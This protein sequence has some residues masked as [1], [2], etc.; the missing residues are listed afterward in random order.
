MLDIIQYHRLLVTSMACLLNPVQVKLAK[1][2]SHKVLNDH[3]SESQELSDTLQEQ[4]L[5]ACIASYA[6]V[7]KRLLIKYS[8]QCNNYTRFSCF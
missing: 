4:D 7:D 5:D 8:K 1:H 3:S 6:S 2:L